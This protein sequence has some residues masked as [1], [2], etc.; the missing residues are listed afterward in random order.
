MMV[1]DPICGT[2]VDTEKAKYTVE[3]WGRK[4]YFDGATCARHFQHSGRVAYFSME[5]GLLSKM[6]TYSGGLGVLAGD[7]IRSCADLRVPLVAVTLLTRQGYL[8]QEL[9]SDGTQTERPDPWDPAAFMTKL[10]N[11]IQLELEGRQVTVG[12]WLYEHESLT[13]GVVPVIFLDTD[14]EDNSPEDRRIC[15]T[16]YGGDT[17]Y[18][19]MQ[20][21][22]LGVAGARMLEALG[23]NVLVFHMNEGHA[24]LLTLELLRRHMGNVDSVRELCV[25]TTHTP[26]EGA[27]DQFSYELTQ[28]VL[29]SFLPANIRDLAGPDRL[30]MT[31]LG[32]NMS[33][34][35]NGVTKAHQAYTNKLFPRHHIRAVTNGIHSHHWTC[36]P[37]RDLFDR[38]ILGWAVEPEL[39]VRA[40]V[41]PNEELWETHVR[42]KQALI[43]T[44]KTRTGVEFDPTVLTI[45]SARRSTAYKR[46]TFFF[47]EPNRLRWIA[48]RYRLQMVFAGK[49][50]YRDEPGK[51]LIRDVFG[52]IE[53][54]KDIVKI[55]Y[56]P[57]YDMELAG[58]L[59]SG[60]DVWLNT[61]LPPYEASGTSGMKAAHN[62]VLNFSVLDGWWLEG[63]I[64]GLT[65]WS[66]GPWPEEN[67]TESERRQR[68]VEDLYDK[69]EYIIAPTFYKNRDAWIQLMKNSIGKIA[70]YFNSHRMVMRYMTDAYVF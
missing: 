55:V 12:A 32:L 64:E 46:P 17:R 49:A 65:G 45:G 68:E 2:P 5:V 26:V 8:R 29:G 60:V 53:Q 4:Y 20:E 58:L 50:H 9:S 3:L 14:L 19:L 33:K 35:E 66:I 28:Q 56:L 61:P 34:Y 10:P 42:A 23:L 6:H 16:L 25:F 15:D 47:S 41:I 40:D 22:I 30:N 52:Y 13:G 62:G 51:Q 11:H 57:D 44:L 70:Y 67:L 27:M 21:A 54:F 43:D 39:L 31:L 7:T 18:R 38:Y 48:R 24:A 59:T 69:F 63:C 37:M 36:R 1:K